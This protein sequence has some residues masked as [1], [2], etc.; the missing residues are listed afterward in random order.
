MRAALK[1]ESASPANVS[2]LI[3]RGFCVITLTIVLVAFFIIEG[4]AV[5]IAAIRFRE[6]FP[7]WGWTLF[8]GVVDLVLAYLIWRG[9]PSS[10]G[11]AIGLLAGINMLFF[12]L[13]LTMTAVAARTMGDKP[14]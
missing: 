1:M 12:G 5:I 2:A 9:W 14:D 6:Q 11:W 3:V 13:S 10:A 8:S 4:I 7:G